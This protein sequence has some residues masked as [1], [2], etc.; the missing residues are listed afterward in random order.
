MPSPTTLF[1]DFD[2]IPDTRSTLQMGM[3]AQPS[4]GAYDHVGIELAFR[5]DAV[6]LNDHLVTQYNVIQNAAR[7]D[8]T[9][10]ANFGVA[11]KLDTS[12]DD[13][14][15]AG[16]NVRIDNHGFRQLNRHSIAHQGFALP[17]PK[18]VVDSGKIRA[19][20]ASQRFPGIG[21]NLRQNG[22]PFGV[23]NGDSIGQIDLA[24]LV[25]RLHLRKGGPEFCGG[26]AVH[27]GIDLVQFTLF[28]RELRLFNDRGDGIARF[29]EN[30][31]IAGRVGE[32]SRQDGRSGI[33][34]LVF[35]EKA[36]KV[37]VRTRGA[38]PGKTITYFA[39]PMARL[40]TSKACPVPFCGCCKTVSTSKGSQMAATFSA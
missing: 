2:E 35:R 10:G 6:R 7:L 19:R 23:Q 38:S 8:D 14:V 31:S 34:V 20:I 17:F 37:C 26:E 21:S 30:A 33:A 36:R 25:V 1:F 12:F 11:K 40:D 28:W 4:K 15:L 32:N 18:R 5:E 9:A 13:G 22:F 3:A 24:M 16:D 27:A 29:A 39:V